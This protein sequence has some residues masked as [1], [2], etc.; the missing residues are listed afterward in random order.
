[1]KNAIKQALETLK[2]AFG[3][4][5]FADPA[6]FRAALADVPI[7]S[8][9]RTIRNL[10]NI[11]MGDMKVYSRLETEVANKN[12][13]TVDNLMT[14]MSSDYMIKEDV[15]KLVV[16][17]IAELLG[18]VPNIQSQPKVIS[19]PIA[20]DMVFV[21]GGTFKMGGTI[22]HGSDCYD[23]EK[24]VHDVTVGDFYI[25]KYQV[26][27]KLWAQVTGGNPSKF[28]GDDLPVENVS[29]NDVQEFIAK[30]NRQT[31][32]KYRL[33]TEAEWEYAA[34][35]GNGGNGYKYA[36]SG[37]IDVVAWYGGNGGD[38]THQVGTRRPNESGIYDMSGNVWEWV[39]DW[40]GGYAAEAQ[41]N[42]QGPPSGSHRVHRGGSCYSAA[43]HCRVS[44]RY[45]HDPG[46]RDGDLGFRLAVS[47]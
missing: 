26:T 13:F 4:S 15:A 33:P 6:R 20:G 38:K 28:L 41:E 18:Y 2:N 47:P 39:S 16:E 8:D 42:P 1:M 17:S 5:I 19:A 3:N 30:L 11:A 46:H 10:L 34:R 31:G 45:G 12:L 27:Q 43:K 23:N 44:L 7:E 37:D 29:W 36:G 35:G 25:G 9:A 40:Y 21:Q 32:K 24:P 14:E 22:E